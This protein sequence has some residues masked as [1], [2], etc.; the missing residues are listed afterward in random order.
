[1]EQW[2]KRVISGEAAGLVPALA[3]YILAFVAVF[4]GLAVRIRSAAF[5]HHWRKIEKLPVPVISVGNLTTGGTGKTPTVIMIVQE[6]IKLGKHP[7]V[8]TRGYKAPQGGMADEVLVIQEECP[9]IPVIINANRVAG[10]REA[11]EKHGA[12]VL[13]LDD[14]YQYRRLA[15]DMNL[16]LVDATSPMGIPGL[17]PRG[18]WRE[19]PAAMAR[20]DIIMLTRCEQV[21]RELAD[22][23]AGLLAEWRSPRAIFQQHTS[24]TGLFDAQGHRVTLRD[25]RAVAFA[26]IAN[27]DGFVRTLES[28]G[29][30]VVS[31]C[32]FGDHHQYNIAEDMPK[33][34]K[35]AKSC[36]VPVLITTLKDWVKLRSAATT[37]PILHVR[38]ACSIAGPEAQIWRETLADVG[39]CKI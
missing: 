20:A 35:V 9:G 23:A 15:R 25:A 12:D 34:V 14:G 39:R 38:I 36:A 30:N 6:L 17:V 22:M 4:Y 19:P 11:I 16:L 29:L 32:W 24:V 7:A 5:D 31:G 13:V 28:M 1:M 2:Y 33:L 8:L 26:G 3:R 10:G 21:P 37:V 18:S 27:P